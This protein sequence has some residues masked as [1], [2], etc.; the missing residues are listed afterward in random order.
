MRGI[1]GKLVLARE[2]VIDP[3]MLTQSIPTHI[4]PEERLSAERGCTGTSKTAEPGSSVESSWG[5]LERW[6]QT[7]LS[8]HLMG[9]KRGFCHGSPLP[10][11]VTLL[12]PD[13]NGHTG[14]REGTPHPH[15]HSI[16]SQPPQRNKNPVVW[17]M[18]QRGS[19]VLNRLESE[20]ALR[21]TTVVQTARFWWRK[22]LLYG[23]TCFHCHITHTG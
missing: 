2:H 15:P 1:T 13:H 20:P 3:G 10:L 7:D 8:P 17:S 16:P 14:V 18:Q 19:N 6:P 9:W 23:Q 5:P 21:W 12:S 4:L 22:H 11:T